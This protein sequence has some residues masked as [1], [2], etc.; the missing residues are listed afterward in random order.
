MLADSLDRSEQ[1]ATLQSIATVASIDSGTISL[2]SPW[3]SLPRRKR[4]RLTRHL[5]GC[6]QFRACVH[7]DSIP[8]NRDR[9][10]KKR[11]NHKGTLQG[12]RVVTRRRGPAILA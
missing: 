5:R 4:P 8:E 9:A 10:K 7:A 1:V 12:H 6:G 3:A 2:S 11:K